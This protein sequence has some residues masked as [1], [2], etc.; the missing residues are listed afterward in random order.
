MDENLRT[1]VGGVAGTETVSK[2]PPYALFIGHA[3]A[4]AGGLM[5]GSIGDGDPVTDSNAR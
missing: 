5:D 2:V 3:Q 1:A 4:I